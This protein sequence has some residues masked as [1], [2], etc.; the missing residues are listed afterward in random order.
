MVATAT[1]TTPLLDGRFR[2]TI[3]TVVM[4]VLAIMTIDGLLTWVAAEEAADTIA[5]VEARDGEV[6]DRGLILDNSQK[7][8]IAAASDG[9]RLDRDKI[10]TKTWMAVIATIAAAALTLASEPGSS[11][12]VLAIVVL[13]AAASFFVPLYFHEDTIDIVTTS[14]GG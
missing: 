8:E 2:A 3:L 7:A 11:R 4:A 12:Q 9:D 14:H 6:D 1:D 5:V 13:I 10:D